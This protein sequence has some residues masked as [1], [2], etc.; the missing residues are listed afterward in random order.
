VSG[1]GTATATITADQTDEFD[2]YKLAPSLTDYVLIWQD[3]PRVEVRTKR[4]EGWLVVTYGPGETIE[5]Q[6][7]IRF[8]VDHSSR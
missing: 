1:G 8:A 6:H 3:E 4:A 7:D 2:H 5:L